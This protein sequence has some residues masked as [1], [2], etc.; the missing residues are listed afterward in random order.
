MPTIPINTSNAILI[1]AIVALA[2]L[3]LYLAYVFLIRKKD[4]NKTLLEINDRL[5]EMDNQEIENIK[6]LKKKK[7]KNKKTATPQEDPAIQPG[8]TLL[9][10]DRISNDMIIKDDG[11]LYSMVIQCRGINLGL[12]SEEE[13]ASVE[14]HF[15]ELLNSM[16]YPFQFHVQTRVL[17][18]NTSIA[19]CAQRQKTFETELKTLVE[20]YNDLQVNQKDNRHEIKET[21]KEILKTQK[22]YDYIKDLYKHVDKMGRNNYVIHSSY[23]ISISCTS[24]EFGIPAKSKK[25][26]DLNLVYNE[27]SDRCSTIIHGLQNCGV[28]ASVLNSRQLAQLIY[29]TF[30]QSDEDLIKLREAMESGI[31]RQ[32]A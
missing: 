5:N 23:Y 9:N 17:D 12:M 19:N 20:K 28:E 30:D 15:I 10:F 16:K 18:F 1:G 11:S 4:L 29:S 27:L 24:G 32:Y 21:A 14:K 3:I 6:N 7:K 26:A 13:K 25:Q 31:L 8:K 22:L 2:L